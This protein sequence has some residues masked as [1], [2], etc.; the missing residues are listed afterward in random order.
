MRTTN[1]RIRYHDV[2]RTITLWQVEMKLTNTSGIAV[3]GIGAT[4]QGRHPNKSADDLAVDA[5]VLALSDAGIPKAQIDGL[6]T[7][8]SRGGNGGD[9]A[10]GKMLGLNPEY[11]ASLDYGT[12]NFSIHL[13]VAVLTCGLANTVLLAYGTN[14]G[15]TV[16]E[17]G[18][19]A[20]LF[21]ES[22][23]GYLNQ[24][25][26]MAAQMFQRH[27]DIYHV[28]EEQ[29]GAISVSQSRWGA[30]NPLAVRGVEITLDD[31]LAAPYLIKPIRHFD[32]SPY[33]DGGGALILTT[34][35][36]A[37]DFQFGAVRILGIGETAPLRQYQN[38]D[39]LDR[40]WTQRVA[41][42]VF[43]DADLSRADIDLV[44]IQDPASTWTM[45]MLEGYGFVG[46]GE[47]LPF[48]EEGHTSPGGKLPVNTS[49]GHLAESYMWGWLHS[50]EVVRQLRGQ[51]G[52]RQVP[53]ARHAMH[54][55]TMGDLKAAATIFGVAS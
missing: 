38:R 50:C 39:H 31:Y 6:I 53:N 30:L 9:V 43:E 11:S 49:G 51:C 21:E 22:V 27:R 1:P 25:G 29:L 17:A 12:C 15:T 26:G 20:G 46:P 47:A 48:I 35:D 55:S 2:E 8:K 37:S 19:S 36:R 32:V 42:H 28:T 3:V 24:I 5:A 4:P 18:F 45:Q 52:E 16:G 10:I 41:K 44:S 40:M 34:A 54:C 13:A 33:D 23:Y 14:Q 7:C